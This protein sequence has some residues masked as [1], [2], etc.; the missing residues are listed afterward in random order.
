MIYGTLAF[1]VCDIKSKHA[2][3]KPLTSNQSLVGTCKK[4]EITH[5]TQNVSLLQFSIVNIPSHS[6]IFPLTRYSE[7]KS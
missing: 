7:I 3:A 1:W 5:F 2:G 6:C 4:L